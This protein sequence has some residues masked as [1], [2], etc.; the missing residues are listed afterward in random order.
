LLTPDGAGVGELA[1]G[2][3]L[4]A[5]GWLGDTAAS[6][7]RDTTVLATGLVVDAQP[8]MAATIPAASNTASAAGM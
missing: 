4:V 5:A 7:C 1:A 2:A 8:A 6:E 3:G